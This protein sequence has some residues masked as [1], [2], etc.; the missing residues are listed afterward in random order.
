MIIRI[1]ARA[2]VD[3]SALHKALAEAF[4]FLPSKYKTKSQL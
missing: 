4:G 3:G 2:L 1:D